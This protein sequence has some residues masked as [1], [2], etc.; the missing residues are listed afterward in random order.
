MSSPVL[1]EQLDSG[2]DVL[3]TD[4]DAAIPDMDSQVVE[5]LGV[6]AELRTLPRPDFRSQL[7]FELMEGAFAASA[8]TRPELR[9]F[10]AVAPRSRSIAS[11]PSISEQVL[12]TLFSRGY[13]SYRV[14]QSNFAISAFVHAV[15]L[16]LLLTSGLWLAD[17]QTLTPEKLTLLARDVS[18]YMTFSKTPA[19]TGG[20]GGGGDRDKVLA[21]KGHLTKMTMQQITPPEVV[22][23]TDH[24][25]FAVE[26]TVVVPPQVNLADSGLSNLGDPKSSVIGPP[27]NGVGYGSGI[28]SGN[29]GGSVLEPALELGRESTPGTV[30][31]SFELVVA[32]ARRA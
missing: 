11:A 27:S 16:S 21:P 2:I 9:V 30:A 10:E 8:A 13:G 20:G 24:P 23:R 4:P 12:P 1:I 26:P 25:K 7:K 6:A 17:Q 3:L 29:G 31:G 19:A 14:R 18:E 28:G 22:V 32:S 15:A 5:L